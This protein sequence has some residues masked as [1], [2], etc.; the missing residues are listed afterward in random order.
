MKKLALILFL[1]VVTFAEAQKTTVVSAF[2][3][4]NRGQL[5]KAKDAIDQATLDEETKGMAKTWAYRGNIYL[6]IFLTDNPKYKGLD[7]NA[8]DVAYEA[9]LKALQLDEKKEFNDQIKGPM[10]I[11]GEQFYNKG[12][13]LYNKKL[14]PDAMKSFEKTIGINTSFGVVDSNSLYNAAL[15][16]ELS[17]DPE[18]LKKSKEHYKKLVEVKFKQPTVYASLSKIYMID[19]DTLNALKVIKKGRS[20]L[21]NNLELIIAETNIYLASGKTKEA[22]ENLKL[23]VEK[24]PNNSNLYFAIGSNY[25]IMAND[26]NSKPAE[27]AIA[28]AEA[29]KA[30]AKAIELKPDF[31]DAIY[32]MGALFFNAGVKVV[33]EANKLTD[34]AQYEIE[35]QKADELFKKALPF[36]EKAEKLQPTDKST[37]FSLKQLYARVGNQERYKEIDAKLKGLK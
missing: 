35:K 30:Y 2:T 25:D 31:F 33:E 11:C 26:K 8:L 24:D 14:Y 36:L 9:Y 15:A 34:N 7:S 23:A 29:E 22:Q 1:F 28:V 4:R 18:L 20:V 32:N 5:D 16:G 12:V 21:G 10:Y 19:K 27:A 3:Y 17:K 13:K 6:D 37:L